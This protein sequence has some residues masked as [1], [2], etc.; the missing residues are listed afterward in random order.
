MTSQRPKAGSLF[1]STPAS[2]GWA[3]VMY[4]WCSRLVTHIRSI[5][6]PGS[7]EEE[8]S[9]GILAPLPAQSVLGVL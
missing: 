4:G 2:G 8:E 1:P 5:H 7:L 6:T 9:P 3:G